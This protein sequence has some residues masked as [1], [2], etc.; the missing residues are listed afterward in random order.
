MIRT[1]AE[2][3]RANISSVRSKILAMGLE[4]EVE[5]DSISI[6]PVLIYSFPAGERRVFVKHKWETVALVRL[7]SK[8]QAERIRSKMNSHF[9]LEENDQDRTLWSKFLLPQG[10][11]DAVRLLDETLRTS[12]EKS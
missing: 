10:E 7:N 11:D 12:E 5:F 1:L 8:E 6:E 9:E 2:P 3:K 4:E